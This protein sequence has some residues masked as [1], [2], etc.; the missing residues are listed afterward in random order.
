MLRGASSSP[1]HGQSRRKGAGLGLRG[2]RREQNALGLERDRESERK[3]FHQVSLA[4]QSLSCF[5]PAVRRRGGEA[6]ERGNPAEGGKVRVWTH[7]KEQ[8]ESNRP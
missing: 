1:G 7:V 5:P 8:H 4:P 2:V 6:T 3:R